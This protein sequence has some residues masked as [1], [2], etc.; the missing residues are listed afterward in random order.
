MTAQLEARLN[1]ELQ[2][3]FGLSLTDYHVLVAISEAPDTRLRMF[4]IVDRQQSRLSHHL[5]RM[6][7]RGLLDR[8]PCPTDGRGSFVVLTDADRA[9]IEQAAPTHVNTVRGLVFDG[10]SPDQLAAL[11]A[12]TAQVLERLHTQPVRPDHQASQAEATGSPT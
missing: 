12:I 4:E 11:T 6:Q 1:R 8:E 10:L 9:A 3:T 2:D 5:S 7:R